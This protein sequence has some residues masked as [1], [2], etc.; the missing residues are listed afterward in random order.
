MDSKNRSKA[1]CRQ[2]PVLG[3]RW[4]ETLYMTITEAKR[5]VGR[6]CW[7]SWTDRVGEQHGQVLQVEDCQYIPMYGAYIIAENEEVRLDKITD[8][9]AVD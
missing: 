9:H 6:N 3:G 4:K 5:F 8:M 7:V 2:E 1:S